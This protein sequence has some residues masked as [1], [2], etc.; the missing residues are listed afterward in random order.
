MTEKAL[1]ARFGIAVAL[2]AVGGFFVLKHS[3]VTFDSVEVAGEPSLA[4]AK[5]PN[6]PAK[7]PTRKAPHGRQFIGAK[8]DTPPATNATAFQTKVAVFQEEV[9]V[10]PFPSAKDVQPGVSRTEL[11]RDFGMPDV[12]VVSSG[13]E[14]LLYLGHTKSTSVTVQNG[15]TAASRTDYFD[16]RG[17]SAPAH[18]NP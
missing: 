9:A 7:T 16:A 3:P 8:S 5:P 18:T 1:L 11:V 6:A 2:L 13:R 17:T 4:A 12:A 15:T 14:R 10:P